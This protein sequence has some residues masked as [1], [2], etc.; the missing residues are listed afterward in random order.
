MAQV[1]VMHV[2]GFEFDSQY[3]K[4]TSIISEKH[5]FLNGS[6]FFSLQFLYPLTLYLKFSDYAELIPDLEFKSVI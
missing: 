1:S 5:L 3:K 6:T 4:K 2:Q